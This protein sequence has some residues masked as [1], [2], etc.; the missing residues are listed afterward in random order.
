MSKVYF[1]TVYFLSPIF[2]I[3]V[4]YG[5]QPDKYSHMSLFIPMCLG[6]LAYHWLNW[7]FILSAKPQFLKKAIGVSK[8][9]QIHGRMALV[10]IGLALVH[11]MLLDKLFNVS[12]GTVLGLAAISIY[13]SVSLVSVIVLTKKRWDK[14]RWVNRIRSM[15]EDLNIFRYEHH[16]QFHNLTVVALFFMQIHVL[17]TQSA[18]TYAFVFNLYMI[19]FLSSLSFYVYHKSLRPWLLEES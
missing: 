9:Y 2:L 6:V 3:R 1:Y 10:S 5:I 7:S 13:A 19:Y 4:L 12:V 15:T 11:Q 17:L 14:W 16:K 18:R 8:I